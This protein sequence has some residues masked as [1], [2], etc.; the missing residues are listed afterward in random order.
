MPKP[1]TV[2]ILA[3]SSASAILLGL[4]FLVVSFVSGRAFAWRQFAGYWYYLV[5][6]AL[7]FGLQIGLFVYLRTAIRERAAT[8]GVVAV[9]GATSTVS[10]LACCAHY[11]TNIL[12]LVATT[13]VVTFATKYQIQ[14]FWVGLA[15]NGLGIGYIA[16][17]VARF[18][19]F[20]PATL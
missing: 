17:K 13:G 19:K 5:P 4:F 3:G 20:S 12:P 11:L 9:T 10:M 8:G 7:G 2:S 16:Q 18:K 14:F 15:M 1:V 6:L